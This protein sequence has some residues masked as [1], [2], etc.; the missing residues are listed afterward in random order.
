MKVMRKCKAWCCAFPWASEREA[1]VI[2]IHYL[3]IAEGD[4]WIAV[5][6]HDPRGA[7]LQYVC[8]D[9]GRDYANH[10]SPSGWST[11]VHDDSLNAILDFMEYISSDTP[12]G[13]GEIEED[14]LFFEGSVSASSKKKNRDLPPRGPIIRAI[15]EVLGRV[16]AIP[17][18]ELREMLSLSRGSLW[19]A[20]TRMERYGYLGVVKLRS[21][22][23]HNGWRS[24]GGFH[25]H[26]FFGHLAGRSIVFTDESVLANYL[27]QNLSYLWKHNVERYG[28]DFHRAL[29]RVLKGIKYKPGKTLYEL[30]EPRLQSMFWR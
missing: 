23:G 12:I 7:K 8:H 10:F 24:I 9:D 30:L 15:K 20:L 17:A 27:W 14:I 5:T 6:H 18:V 2:A 19:C 16:R 4:G 26:D 22:S 13:E 1:D 3:S 25:A 21:N 29:V 11:R 28:G